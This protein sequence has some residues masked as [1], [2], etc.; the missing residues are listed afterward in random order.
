MLLGVQEI[1]YLHGGRSHLGKTYNP[2]VRPISERTNGLENE[3][4]ELCNIYD[5]NDLFKPTLLNNTINYDLM[6]RRA[7]VFRFFV[8]FS[9]TSVLIS[10]IVMI[11]ECCRKESGYKKLSE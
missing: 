10:L 1:V 6:A 2:T 9:F 3:F 7:I 4:E 11:V 8:G 5:P